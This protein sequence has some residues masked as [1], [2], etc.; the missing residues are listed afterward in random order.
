MN[1]EF[2]ADFTDFGVGVSFGQSH[3][4]S[5]YFYN[6]TINFMFFL[7]IFRFVKVKDSMQKQEWPRE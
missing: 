2:Y 3:K 6:L 7:I 1:I 5:G 4:C